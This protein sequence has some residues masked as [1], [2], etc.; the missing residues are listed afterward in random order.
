M[1]WHKLTPLLTL[2]M[3]TI[4]SF[5]VLWSKIR[6]QR[7]LDVHLWKPSYGDLYRSW[8]VSIHPPLERSPS[9]RPLEGLPGKVSIRP[10][11]GVPPLRTRIVFFASPCIFTMSD[12]MDS[13]HRTNSWTKQFDSIECYTKFH[14]ILAHR[15]TFLFPPLH[16]YTHTHN[17]L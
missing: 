13:S 16:K 17:E 11:P 4:V 7:M 8:E 10:L 15:K 14:L 2:I 6:F 12:R 5:E 9:D 3:I 1:V